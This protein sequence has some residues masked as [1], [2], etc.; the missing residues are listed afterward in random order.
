M[1]TSLGLIFLTGMALGWVC[2]KCRL[3]GLLGMMAA[4]IL[5]AARIYPL[6]QG[7]GI[8]NSAVIG[9]VFFKEPIT[10]RSLLGLSVS[11]AALFLINF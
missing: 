7:L 6:I 3:P 10:R 8:I 4:G 1:L 2:R 11:A 9:A 5:P